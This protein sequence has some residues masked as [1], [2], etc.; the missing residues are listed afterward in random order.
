MDWEA[1]RNIT[2][3]LAAVAAIV[4]ALWKLVPIVRQWWD[5]RTL[6]DLSGEA[7][8]ADD[9]RRYTGYYIQPDCQSVDPSGLEDF[10]SIVPTRVPLFSAMDGILRN[11]GTMRY[12]IILADS[13]MGKTAFLLNYYARHRRRL[14][15]RKGDRTEACAS[16]PA[17]RQRYDGRGPR[18]R[19][20]E[21]GSVPRR[22]RRGS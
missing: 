8:S 12:I 19:P 4:A 7:Y 14:W 15:R 9:A 6:L 11:P 3:S 5:R 21:D 13:G 10:R 1:I 20:Q 17:G 16:Q 18:C 22:A 2:A